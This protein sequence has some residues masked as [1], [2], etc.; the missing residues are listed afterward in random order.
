MYDPPNFDFCNTFH[1]FSRFF[2]VSANRFKDASQAPKYCKNNSLTH[3]IPPK[4]FQEAPKSPPRSFQE[5]RRALQDTPKSSQ[6]ASKRPQEPPKRLQ[7]PPKSLP[8]GPRSAARRHK[9][10]PAAPK[11]TQMTPSSPPRGSTKPPRGS[12]KLPRGSQEPPR[13]PQ[14]ALSELPETPKCLPGDPQSINF[15]TLKHH[16]AGEPFSLSKHLGQRAS[17]I[18]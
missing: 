13:G 14:T 16:Q 9:M 1:D 5:A 17:P 18:I 7:E 15:Q 6:E 8:R 12:K 2:N 11:I 3:E 4:C 10:R